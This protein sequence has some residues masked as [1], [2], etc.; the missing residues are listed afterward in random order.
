MGFLE[1]ILEGDGSVIIPI[2]QALYFGDPNID[3]TWRIIR[4][5]DRL[6]VERRELGIWNRKGGWDT[7]A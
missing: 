6:D 2:G 4:I 1:N 3:G 7:D 5:A